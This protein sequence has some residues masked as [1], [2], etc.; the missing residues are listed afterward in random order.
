MR[1][2]LAARAVMIAILMAGCAKAPATTSAVSSPTGSTST[3]GSSSGTGT[4][5]TMYGSGDRSGGGPGSLGVADRPVEWMNV[6]QGAQIVIQ[7]VAQ[8]YAGWQVQLGNVLVGDVVEV[9]H[10]SA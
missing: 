6:L 3:S 2:G 4:T 8:R 10:Q 9:L 1:R 7:L 5:G